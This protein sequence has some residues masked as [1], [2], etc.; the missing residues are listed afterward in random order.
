LEGRAGSRRLLGGRLGDRLLRVVGTEPRLRGP[1]GQ[2]YDLVAGQCGADLRLGVD[3]ERD[4]GPWPR[5]DQ[6]G[7]LDP[8]ALDVLAEVLG[9]PLVRGEHDQ[10]QAVRQVVGGPLGG[11]QRPVAVPAGDEYP[12]QQQRRQEPVR[13]AGLGRLSQALLDRVGR[14]DELG[15]R[16]FRLV[17]RGWRSWR[18]W[19]GW[20]GWLGDHFGVDGR[21]G[22]AR[23]VGRFALDDLGLDDL[24]LDDL[25][26]DDLRLVACALGRRRGNASRQRAG[27]RVP[28]GFDARLAVAEAAGF[29]AFRWALFGRVGLVR[30]CWLTGGRLIGVSQWRLVLSR[31]GGRVALGRLKAAG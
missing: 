21:L 18:G 4:R 23:R 6:L 30:R 22:T 11:V 25:A 15:F 24:G 26:V 13:T 17:R 12:G 10:V 27:G 16:H 2:L 29:F 28:A 3:R 7:E 14:G 9:H 5:P 1:V 19:R 8:G 31:G 20:R